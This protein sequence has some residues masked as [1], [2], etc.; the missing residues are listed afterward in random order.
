MRARFLLKAAGH[1]IFMQE[2]MLYIMLLDP[3]VSVQRCNYV[4]R[5]L[6]FVMFQSRE[7]KVDR[8]GS[9]Y[10]SAIF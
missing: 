8:L 4:V 2:R 5:V 1:E 3:Y 10:S 9:L 7:V 6:C